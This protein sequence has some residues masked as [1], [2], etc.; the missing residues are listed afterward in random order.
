M[1]GIY[2]ADIYCDD[3]IDD[4]KERICK[5]LWD[6]RETTVCPDGS[7]CRRF[8]TQLDLY[9]YLDSMDET[10]YDSDDY[11][12]YCSDDEETDSPGHCGSHADCLNPEETSDGEKYGHFFGN[13]L[14]TEGSDYVKEAVDDDLVSGR[15][16]S[17]AVELWKPHYDYIDY[18]EA[19]AAC[20]NYAN[21]EYDTCEDCMADEPCDGDFTITPCGHLGGMS[22]VGVIG[23]KFVGEFHSDYEAIMAIRRIMNDEKFWPNIWIV[24]DHGNWRLYDD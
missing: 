5:E 16:D 18:I 19:C 24:S 8:E 6:R 7:K 2:N 13:S 15:T 1:A 4:T 11:P 21:L 3:C 23:G 20:G 17:P 12:K 10:N 14:T 22:G 9:D